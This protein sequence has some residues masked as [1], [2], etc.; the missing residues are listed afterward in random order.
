MSGGAALPLMP[1]CHTMLAQSVPGITCRRPLP[2]PGIH[3]RRLLGR[4]FLSTDPDPR[5]ART[6][7][8]R[9]AVLSLR[10]WMVLCAGGG[11]SS[12]PGDCDGLS[13]T[14][15]VGGPRFKRT[16]SGPGSQ[17]DTNDVN[18]DHSRHSLPATWTCLPS[19]GHG[20]MGVRR[21]LQRRRT[22]VI[23]ECV[24]LKPRP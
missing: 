17:H 20:R 10:N 11:G 5:H 7:W 8:H 22:A 16:L 6:V 1:G 4:L 15:R 13:P 12:R 23:K 9:M 14:V 19:A 18:F 3:V 2:R 21:M 24:N